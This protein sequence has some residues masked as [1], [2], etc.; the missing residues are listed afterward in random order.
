MAKSITPL[1]AFG[2]GVALMYYLDPGR[3]ARRRA[4][5]RD[6]VV[7]ALHAAEDA[8]ET[9]V[10]DLRNRTKGVVAETRA[11]FND[12]DA[13]DAVIVA[14]VRA[15]LGR[16]VSHPSSIIAT[17]RD[18]VVT[19]SGPVLAGEVAD[20]TSS[21]RG[22]RGV[23][24]VVDKLEVHE[25]AANV[26][27][28]QG[29]GSRGRA[30]IDVLQESWS[31]A[32]R[33]LIGAAGGALALAGGRRGD[34][35]G[36]LFS[37]VGLG[38]LSRAATNTEL[39]SLVGAGEHGIEI[40]KSINITAPID[41]VFG[42][43]SDYENFP[44]FMSHVREV[45]D[46]GDNMSHWVVDGPGKFAVEWDAMLT[47]FEPPEIIAWSSVP[48]SAVESAGVIR[49]GLNDDGTTHV[50]VHMTYSPPAGAIGHVA[51]KLFHRDPKAQMDDDLVRAKTYLETGV[52]ARDAAVTARTE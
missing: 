12:G 21:V 33:L 52:S 29:S 26:P 42:F 47:E 2:A 23:R 25:R 7:H 24:D 19:L 28:L 34:F 16:A 46:L 27:G 5:L 31:P 13:D 3:G 17:A 11:R 45:R 39:R 35:V 9:T 41:D 30:G 1:T 37:L 40:N 14:R 50:Q 6:K 36:S 38:L 32:T 43:F 4:L 22:V 15:G 51:A 44:S 48:G 10:R 18:G 20:L 8:A 49:F